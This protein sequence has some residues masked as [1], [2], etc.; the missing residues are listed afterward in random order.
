MRTYADPTREGEL[1]ALPDV[2]VFYMSQADFIHASEDTWMRDRLVE[3]MGYCGNNFVAAADLAGWY[4]WFCFPG[5]LPDSDA[6]GPYSTEEEA[7][8]SMREMS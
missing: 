7:V 4:F 2:E 3:E 5:C 6:F 1:Y 8:S